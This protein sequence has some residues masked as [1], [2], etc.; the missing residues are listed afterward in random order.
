MLWLVL[1]VIENLKQ[2]QVFVKNMIIWTKKFRRLFFGTSKFWNK[3]SSKNFN[4]VSILWLRKLSRAVKYYNQVDI[5]WCIIS[6]FY[7]SYCTMILEISWLQ[8][9]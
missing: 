5:N 1:F 3:V 2:N 9:V 7:V 8:K 4:K 6:G